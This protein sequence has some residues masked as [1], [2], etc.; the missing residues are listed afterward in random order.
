MQQATEAAKRHP[1]SIMEA[2]SELDREV[3]VRSRCFDKWVT[4]GR[5]SWSDARD[6]MARLGAASKLLLRLINEEPETI[7]HT[8]KK[9]G[10]SCDELSQPIQAEQGN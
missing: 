3:Q 2:Q 5:I 10:I 9:I 4:E 7:A 6:R 8:C 1:V